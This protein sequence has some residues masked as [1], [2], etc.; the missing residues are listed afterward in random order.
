MIRVHHD[1]ENPVQRMAH[2][3]GSDLIL[4][5]F[6]VWNGGRKRITEDGRGL[7]ECD[8]MFGAIRLGLLETPDE[9]HAADATI[10]PYLQPAADRESRASHYRGV[11]RS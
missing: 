11:A 8:P 5:V 4:R 9:P 1:E 6:R 10:G 7:F 3:D 2:C